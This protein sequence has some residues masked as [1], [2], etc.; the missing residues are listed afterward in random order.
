MLRLLS[1][2][3]DC[4]RSRI[5]WYPWCRDGFVNQDEKTVDLFTPW[6]KDVFQATPS[7]CQRHA[8]QAHCIHWHPWYRDEHAVQVVKAIEGP[9]FRRW[10]FLHCLFCGLWFCL[11]F[12]SR[13]WLWR[14]SCAI[15]SLGKVC[16]EMV[17][18]A[19]G[20]SSVCSVR[21]LVSIVVERSSAQTVTGTKLSNTAEFRPSKEKFSCCFSSQSPP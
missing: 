11:N 17:V 20:N 5:H 8:H 10:I 15:S 13:S 14:W 16:S 7:C 6:D 19:T 3:L 4:L 2:N 12:L 9:G 18:V 1:A 21:W